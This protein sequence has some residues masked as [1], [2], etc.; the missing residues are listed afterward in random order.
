MRVAG[1]L[2]QLAARMRQLG[3]SDTTLSTPMSRTD[4][5]NHLGI[6]LECLSRVLGRFRTVGLIRAS[7]GEIEL[8]RPAEL[9]TLACHL[10]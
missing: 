9:E 1:F 2:I 3:R 4:L 5:A 7:R 6:T 8:L 10:P